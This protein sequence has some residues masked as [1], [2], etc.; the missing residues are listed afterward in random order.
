MTS[1]P[2]FA[3]SAFVGVDTSNPH[4]SEVEYYRDPKNHAAACASIL[5]FAQ[6]STVWNFQIVD[7]STLEQYLVKTSTFPGFMLTEQRAL[8][9]QIQ[10]SEWGI[11]V[12]SLVEMLEDQGERLGE[13]VLKRLNDLAATISSHEGEISTATLLLQVIRKAEGE[14]AVSY[15]AVRVKLALSRAAGGKIMVTKEEGP[16]MHLR[17]QVIPHFLIVNAEAL[18][19]RLREISVEEWCQASTTTSNE[20]VT[21]LA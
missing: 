2:V 18:A 14:N 11:Y 3:T 4:A 13:P 15:S 21:T 8:S 17:L 5:H 9:T 19:Q 1:N 20:A 6:S 10:A 12:R 16:L 7:E